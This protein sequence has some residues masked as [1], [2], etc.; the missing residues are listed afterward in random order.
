MTTISARRP[1]FALPLRTVTQRGHQRTSTPAHLGNFEASAIARGTYEVGPDGV[2]LDVWG[3][4]RPKSITS[5]ARHGGLRQVLTFPHSDSSIVY[6]IV[7]GAG[8]YTGA[9]PGT[10]A[11]LLQ[12]ASGRPPGHVAWEDLRG[13]GYSAGRYFAV[14]ERHSDLVDAQEEFLTDLPKMLNRQA[15]DLRIIL[16]G[17][18]LG[19]QV[20]LHVA[21]RNPPGLSGVVALAPVVRP[22]GPIGRPPWSAVVKLLGLMPG[23][24]TRFLHRDAMRRVSYAQKYGAWYSADYLSRKEIDPYLDDS[25]QLHSLRE[26][27]R[28]G[29]ELL[30][31]SP[32]KVPIRFIHSRA[33]TTCDFGSV[34]ELSVA[35]SERGGDV[36][37][38]ELQSFPHQLLALRPEPSNEVHR[39]I[40]VCISGVLQ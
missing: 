22:A 26:L 34:A 17:F 25:V 32:P 40:D 30:Q 4:G 36:R 18:S 6:V 11:H 23:L 19:A 31:S 27:M 10:I 24:R 5:T 39:L 16:V 1:W 2:L 13:Y 8:A 29:T 33:D 21:R 38:H 35:W 28:A 14:V 3:A 9:Y 7:G 20:A 15:S 12:P 37:L